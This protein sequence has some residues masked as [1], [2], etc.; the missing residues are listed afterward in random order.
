MN[1]KTGIKRIVDLCMAVALLFL[2]SW[3]LIGE[4]AHEV[5]GCAMFALMLVHVALNWSWY[6]S[7]LK[8]SWPSGRIL[9][10]AVDFLVLACMLVSCTS[11]ILLSRHVFAPLGI[12]LGPAGNLAIA[13]LLHLLSSYWGFCLM[14]VH[15]GMHWNVITFMIR[16]RRIRFVMN[17]LGICAAAYGLVAF[18]VRGIGGY[19]LLLTR[20]VFFD[21]EEPSPLFL[22]DYAA[23]MAL[24]A[25]IGVLLS[26]MVLRA[27]KKAAS[28][29]FGAAFF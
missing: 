29:L 4:A 11:G 8:G 13:R 28:A 25:C 3:A 26:K 10:T 2:M 6:R 14:S 20:F 5:L 9:Q 21:F 22:A 23:I 7:L 19:L 27:Q 16:D 1:V 12:V 17:A 18:V 24:C 15:L